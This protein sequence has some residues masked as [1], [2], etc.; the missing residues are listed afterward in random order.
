MFLEL[1]SQPYGETKICSQ[2]RHSKRG[3]RAH[4][5]RVPRR[6]KYSTGQGWTTHHPYKMQKTLLVHH[7]GDPLQ[8]PLLSI[9]EQAL[10]QLEEMR[11]CRPHI[12]GDI[13]AMGVTEVKCL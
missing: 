3:L 8:L 5:L 9:I 6:N 11:L 1:I 10:V 2:H 7:L 13:E 4:L 12:I